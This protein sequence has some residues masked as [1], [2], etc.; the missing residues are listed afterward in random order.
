MSL[1]ALVRVVIFLPVDGSANS[2]HS[3]RLVALVLNGSVS[4]FSLFL[5]I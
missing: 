2:S 3:C 5:R 4:N 1:Y